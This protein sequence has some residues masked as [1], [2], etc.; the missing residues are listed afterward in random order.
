MGHQMND[1]NI[2]FSRTLLSVVVADVR[3]YD[4][5]IQIQKA[6]VHSTDRRTWEFHGPDKFYTHFR[7]DNAFEARAK[8]WQAW[9]RSKGVDRDDEAAE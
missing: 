7:A 3:K 9:L 6:W 8:G 5:K 4:S 1:I 2:A